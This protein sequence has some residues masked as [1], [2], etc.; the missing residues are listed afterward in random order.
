MLKAPSVLIRERTASVNHVGR[1][2]M[3]LSGGAAG[4]PI[5]PY[6]KTN[7]LADALQP[8][9]GH[10]LER[11]SAHRRR[12]AR[13]LTARDE[14]GS[15]RYKP[16]SGSCC[17]FPPTKG[18]PAQAIPPDRDGIALSCGDSCDEF[19][20][21]WHTATLQERSTTRLFEL[22]GLFRDPLTLPMPPYLGLCSGCR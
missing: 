19:P 16:R 7:G 4:R 14:H 18:T 22:P 9:A 5:N 10:N 21:R 15:P 3:L 17:V 12:I 1:A 11:A 6:Q 8:S 20:P 13:S 2:A